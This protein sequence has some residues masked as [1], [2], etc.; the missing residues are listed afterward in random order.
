[1]EESPESYCEN[2]ANCSEYPNGENCT[3]CENG[4][5]FISKSELEEFNLAEL[6]IEK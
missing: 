6:E 4:S 1:M 2:C 5:N 3:S